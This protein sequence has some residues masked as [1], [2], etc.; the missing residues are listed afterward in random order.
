[1]HSR[2][3]PPIAGRDARVLILGSLPGQ[4]SLR[5]RQYYAQPRNAFWPIMEV[6]CGAGPSLPYRARTRRLAA[7]GLALWD[8]CA[9]AFRAG[10]LDASIEPGSIVVND[11]GAFLAEHPRIRLVCFNGRTAAALYRRRVL[12]G[13][14][15][16]QAALATLELPSTSPAHAALPFDAKLARWRAVGDALGSSGPARRRRAAYSA[17]RS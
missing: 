15:P 6:V 4:E 1:M 5:R 12:P 2:G 14:S 11:F 3:F 10:S 17:P 9:T 8:V 13:L 16:A 7:A